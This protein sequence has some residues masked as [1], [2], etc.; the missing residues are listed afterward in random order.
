MSRFHKSL[1]L[2]MV[3]CLI[4]PVLAED[5]FSEVRRMKA[6]EAKQAVAADAE[7]FYAITN[8]QIGKYELE[9]G[10]F[11]ERWAASDDYPLKHLNSGIVRDGQ[12]ICA[13]SNYPQY[14]EASSI[15]VWDTATLQ[16]ID[17]HSFGIYEG[18]LTWIDWKDD[19][20]WAVF[21]HYSK[22]IE[23]GT[24]VKSTRWTS[25]VQFDIN[26][27]R[28]AAWVFPEEV[29][30][31]F[32]PHSCSGGAWGPDGALYCTGHDHAEVYRLTL[33][34]AGSTLRLTHTFP[35][36]ITGQG[37]AWSHDGKYLLGIDRKKRE[38]IICQPPQAIAESKY[39][40]E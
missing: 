29:L 27:H 31:R 28:Q 11:V 16:H 12:L 5:A 10:R 15:E 13:H 36:P 18:S 19:A 38:V 37:I 39:G 26:W 3:S 23:K 33:P 6:A 32:E 9:S 17:S 34:K 24:T 2:L 20:W 35:A 30:D 25:L 7:H 1:L 4:R 8:S 14:P 22:G 21:A 40:E